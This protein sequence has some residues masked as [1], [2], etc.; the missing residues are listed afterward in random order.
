VKTASR[1]PWTET[2]TFP[3]VIIAQKETKKQEPIRKGRPKSDIG[4]LKWPLMICVPYMP[5][6]DPPAHTQVN[7][8]RNSALQ[9]RVL[10][11]AVKPSAFGL[12]QAPEGGELRSTGPEGGTTELTSEARML[13]V[14]PRISEMWNVLPHERQSATSVETLISSVAIF[15]RQVGQ[16][17]CIELGELCHNMGLNYGNRGYR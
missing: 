2:E 7:G 5:N 15:A 6:M 10:A 11:P 16:V 8:T 3:S 9:L 1:S 14:P 12:Y 4:R 17:I 13:L